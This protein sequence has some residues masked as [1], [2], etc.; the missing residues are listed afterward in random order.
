[1]KQ[2]FK[3]LCAAG[4]ICSFVSC[5][6]GNKK[7]SEEEPIRATDTTTTTVSTKTTT[8]TSFIPF[9]VVEITQM[10]NDYSKW[11]PFFNADSA[12]RQA[13]GLEDITVGKN[14]EKPNNIVVVLKA[15]DVQKAKNFTSSAKLKEIM[16][17]AG[18]SKPEFHF[19]HIIRFNP[20]SK[21]NQ[22][23]TVTHKVKDFDAW[24]KV[25]D[26]E[27]T[28]SRASQGLIDLV[29]ARGIDDSNMVHL[30]FDTKEMAKAKESMLSDSKK[31]LMMSAGVIGE[32]QIEFYSTAK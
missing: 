12:F 11:R 13:S 20:Q 3:I 15:S 32:P 14:V 4:I 2:L 23:V 7:V 22:W 18:V 8:D 6:S 17:K 1:M 10:V 9:D 24:L 26:N 25:F 30:V 27:G 19:W 21:E 16:Q 29:I 31:K 5:N 28:A